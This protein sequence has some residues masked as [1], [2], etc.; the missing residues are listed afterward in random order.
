MGWCNWLFPSEE[1][2]IPAVS[3]DFWPHVSLQLNWSLL[4]LRCADF[5]GDVDDHNHGTVPQHRLQAR[6]R[7]S[8]GIRTVFEN[9][10]EGEDGLF[11]FFFKVFSV[12][13]VVLAMRQKRIMQIIFQG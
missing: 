9:L 12:E 3:T 10:K 13:P 1:N 8:R 11:F 4:P 7:L 5:Q 6:P 2:I